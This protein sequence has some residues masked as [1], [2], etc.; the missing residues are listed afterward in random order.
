MLVSSLLKGK[1]KKSVLLL[2]G[3]GQTY[4]NAIIS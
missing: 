4:I 1:I 3:Y 2:V